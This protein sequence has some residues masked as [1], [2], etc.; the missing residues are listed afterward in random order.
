MQAIQTEL[1]KT[2]SL[3]WQHEWIWEHWRRND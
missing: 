1:A 2:H 3:L